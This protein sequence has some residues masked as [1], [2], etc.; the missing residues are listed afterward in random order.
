M[1]GTEI[2]L[3]KTDLG[4]LRLMQG[5]ARITNADIARELEMAPSAV[6]ERVKKL[7]QK[8]V[9]LQYTARINPVAVN[10][11]LLAFISMKSSE[12]MGSNNTAKE[13]AK[14]PEVQEVHHIAGEDCYL[15]KVRTADSASLM[16]LMRNTF[17]HIPNILSTR[18]TI[19]LETVKE[20]QQLVI[21]EK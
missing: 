5:N 8:Q 12:G 10:Q 4:I 13:L 21:P 20:E 2:I 17:S 14:I 6:L 15:V 9:I 18:T 16:N 1:N 11:K 19:V 3:D 7:E